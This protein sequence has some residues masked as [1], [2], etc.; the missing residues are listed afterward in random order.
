VCLSIPHMLFHMS[1]C[2]IERHT[3]VG[4]PPPSLSIEKDMWYRKALYASIPPP[5]KVSQGSLV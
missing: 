4:P 1:I 5:S 3:I 2:G